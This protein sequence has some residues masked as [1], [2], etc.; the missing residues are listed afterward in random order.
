[1]KK[2]TNADLKT[3]NRDSTATLSF[4]TKG[5]TYQSGVSSLPPDLSPPVPYPGRTPSFAG[6]PSATQQP[7]WRVLEPWLYRAAP[8][9][10]ALYHGRLWGATGPTGGASGDPQQ[11]GVGRVGVGMVA[12]VWLGPTGL[13]PLVWECSEPVFCHC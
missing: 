13:V 12:T 2:N 10:N 4:S 8:A 1:M 9:A 7:Q 3:N 5:L 11:W 6:T